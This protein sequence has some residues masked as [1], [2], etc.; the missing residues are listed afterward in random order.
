MA[1]NEKP[2]FSPIDP[3]TFVSVIPSNFV[4]NEHYKFVSVIATFH[5]KLAIILHL[6]KQFNS[7]KYQK[8]ILEDLDLY[9]EAA[10]FFS[11]TKTLVYI[12]LYNI[13]L[14]DDSCYDL[15]VLSF[16]EQKKK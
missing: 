5:H 3:Q 11:A 4:S 10:Y 12:P 7:F 14:E 9:I 2:C 6:L 1:G 13:I 16:S 8:I 15:H